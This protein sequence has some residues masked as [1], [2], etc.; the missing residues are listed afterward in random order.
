MVNLE[1]Q[2]LPTVIHDII[3]YTDIEY[4]DPVWDVNPNPAV[5]SDGNV[6]ESAFTYVQSYR[7]LE[8]ARVRL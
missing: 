6:L 1:S 4:L 7:V 2:F 3:R 8:N 5:E